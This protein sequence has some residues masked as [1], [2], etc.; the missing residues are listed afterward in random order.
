M[1]GAKILTPSARMRE[2]LS[3]DFGRSFIDREDMY[4]QRKGPCGTSENKM[5]FENRDDANLHR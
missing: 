4:G 1:I 3:N 5:N 2:V